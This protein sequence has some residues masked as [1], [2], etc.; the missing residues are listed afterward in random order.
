MISV[1]IKII[2]SLKIIRHSNVFESQRENQL[3]VKW[4][5]EIDLKDVCVFIKDDLSLKVSVRHLHLQN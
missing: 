1:R 3:K 5:D 4:K 2:K